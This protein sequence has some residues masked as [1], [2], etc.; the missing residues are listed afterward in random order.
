[1]DSLEQEI[2]SQ[3]QQRQPQRPAKQP[4]ARRACA[5]AAGGRL[6]KSASGLSVRT[7]RWPRR[8]SGTKS[9]R[10]RPACMRR[11]ARRPPRPSSPRRPS[12]PTTCSRACRRWRTFRRSRS[13]SFAPS[14]R[15]HAAPTRNGVR[16][17]FWRG[18]R[19]VSV[20][21]RTRNTTSTTR[22]AEEEPR[23]V[24]AQPPIQHAPAPA[25]ASEFAKQPQPRRMGEQPGAAGALDPRGR[26]VPVDPNR[27]DH[28]EIPAFLRRQ[29][30]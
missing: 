5:G 11:C 9:I 7:P 13:A 14:R 16:A 20:A 1:M 30:S 15:R 29:S 26:P 18:L 12:G 22:D 2:A 28:L 8:G 23:V 4:A 6:A 3:H 19:A 27:D 21:V 24:Q 25:P 17:G 10:R